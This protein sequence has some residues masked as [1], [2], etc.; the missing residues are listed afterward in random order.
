MRDKRFTL[1]SFLISLVVLLATPLMLNAQTAAEIELAKQMARKQGYSENQIN[2]MIKNQHEKEIKTPAVVD[3]N[4][5]QNNVQTVTLEEMNA[6]NRSYKEQVA[7]VTDINTIFGHSIFKNENLNFQPSYNMPTPENYK[8]SAGDEVVIDVWGAVVTNIT[9]KIS[10]EGSVN[11][12]DLGPIYIYGQTVV[13]AEKNIKNYL[14]KIYSGINDSTPDTFV[15]LSLGKIKS[16]TVNVVGD[17]EIPGTYTIPALSSIPSAMFL[18]GGPNNMGTVR[19]IKVYRNGKQVGSFDVYG[20]LVEGKTGKNVVLEDNDA[21]VVG[22]HVGVVSVMG[23]VKRPMNYEIKEGETLADLFK[24]SGGFSSTAYESF[25]QVDR[26]KYEGDK[27]GAIAQTFNVP[28]ADYAS[29]GLKD[30]DVVTVRKNDNRFANK[31][32]ITGAVWHPGS[33]S[34]SES[35]DLKQLL[36]NAGGVK[37]DAYLNK[38]YIIRFGENREKEQVSF[39][40]NNVILGGDR[41]NLMPDDSVR[42]FSILDLAPEQTIRVLGEVNNP[43]TE[44]EYRKGMTIGD[45]ILMAGGVNEAATLEKVEIARRIEVGEEPSSVENVSDTI[46]MVLRYNLLKNPQDVDAPLE[47]FDMIFVRKSVSYKPQQGIVVEGEVNYPGTYVIEKNVVRLSDVVKRS[48]GFTQDAYIQGAKLTRVLTEEEY[49]RLAIAVSIAKKQAKDSTMIDSLELGDRYT[50]AID[51]KAAVEN[52]GSY[53]DVVLRENDIL[54]VPQLNNTVKISGGVLYTN[55]ISY[56]PKSNYKFY[57]SNAG[58]YVKNAM[59]KKTYMVHMNGSVATRGSKGFKVHPGTEII[60]PIKDV[61][62][63]GQTLAALMSVATSTASLA[64]MIVT[65]MNTTK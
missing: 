9:S 64:A 16:V 48:E 59:K 26:Y 18:A 42:I 39:N 35:S 46:A 17:V 30:G 40:L 58:G 65:I 27:S 23:S 62:Q 54:L 2:A 36:V 12:P 41:I 6:T 37:D 56:N 29:F 8:L 5:V 53:A 1:R 25:V 43:N 63:N 31:V 60:V 3:R 28:A 24:Y 7:P 57:I 55:T 50:I 51:L 11:I 20:Y 4:I 49:E 15:K 61:K 38:G 45:A 44:F 33:Y 13:Q 10:P 32:T 22:T 14:S 47:P 34:L 21:I 19:D 52:P